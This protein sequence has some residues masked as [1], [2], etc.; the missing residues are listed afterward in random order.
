[1]ND[2]VLKLLAVILIASALILLLRSYKAEYAFLLSLAA[3]VG[4]LLILLGAIIPEISR[5]RTL[6]E[7]SGNASAY[8]TIALKALGIAYIT[9]FAADTCRDFGQ[10]ALAQIADIAGKCAVFVLS[11]PLMCAV[12]ET[13]L[14]FIKI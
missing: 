6:F 12:L 5:V 1:M 14:K 9:G 2:T 4:V 11:I 3:A 8:F 7:K 13:A 10:T